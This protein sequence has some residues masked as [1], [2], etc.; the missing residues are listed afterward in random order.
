M[1]LYQLLRTLL[2]VPVGV[3]FRQVEVI[4][5]ENVPDEGAR[6]ALLCGNHPN[7]LIDPLLIIVTSPRPVRLAAKDVL[8]KTL[9]MRA[10]LRGVGAVPVQR[11]SDH[12]NVDNSAMFDAMSQVLAGGG[13][14]GIFPEGLSHD[15]AQLQKLK[16]GAARIALDTAHRHDQAVD[17]VPVGLTYLHPKRFRSRVV[18]QYGAPI[19]VGEPWRHAFLRDEKGAVR[20]LTADIDTALRELTVNAEDW[21][22]ARLLNAVRRL[23]QPPGIA[24]WQRVELA[25]RFN[26]AYPK[27][28]DLPDVRALLDQVRD[29]LERLRQLD[30]D[31]S[32]VL[33]R[34]GSW[35]VAGKCALR[36]LDALV[37]A[38]LA[39]PGLVLQ[40]PVALVIG[41][42]GVRFSPR[43]DVIG[44]TKLM[45]GLVLVPLL[46]ACLI[47]L[48]GWAFG[49]PWAVALA[50]LLPLSGWAA[51]R[52][53]ETG[54]RVWEMLQTAGRIAVLRRELVGLRATRDRLQDEVVRLVDKYRPA[55]MVPLFERPAP[56]DA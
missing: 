44:T 9:P 20:Q 40:G 15:E 12:G 23:Y 34:V 11:K 3:F 6:A 37:W 1:L 52:A 24:L 8:F 21:E 10:L 49:W 53:L 43:K 13:A 35:E 22:T 27:V 28:K 18:V 55:N 4:G 14:M 5:R 33:R 39:L 51:L 48:V 42:F 7:S 32:D 38:P 36:L 2:K 26:A 19:E 16:T 31:D 29:Y 47:G 25:R 45:M 17:V 56:K 46:H 54:L 41:L 30:L 50:V